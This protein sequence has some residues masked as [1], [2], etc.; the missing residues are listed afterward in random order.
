VASLALVAAGAAAS[1]AS[2][3]VYVVALRDHREGQAA[4]SRRASIGFPP[5]PGFA[6]HAG[7][8]VRRVRVCCLTSRDAAESMASAPRA[9]VTADAQ[10]VEL[11]PGANVSGCAE[12]S[13]GFL[14]G[15]D[16]ELVEDGGPVSFGV[17]VAGVEATV[18]HDGERWRMVQEG[19]APPAL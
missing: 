15:Y 16:W 17:A 10:P 14:N 5:S 12:E 2:W 1:L 7:L 11:S 8:L 6:T 13:V 18:V 4:S 9:R 19:E 3:A